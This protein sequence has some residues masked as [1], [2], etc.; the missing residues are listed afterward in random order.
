M[1]VTSSRNSETWLAVTSPGKSQ[2]NRDFFRPSASASPYP[3]LVRTL[4]KGRSCRHLSRVPAAAVPPASL[5]RMAARTALARSGPK[6]S[7]TART[8]ASSSLVTSVLSSASSFRSFLRV[9]DLS[10]DFRPDFFT[11]DF[12]DVPSRPVVASVASV[13]FFSSMT[14]STMMPSSSLAGTYSSP[15]PS[16][17]S[18]PTSTD[19][20]FISSVMTLSVIFRCSDTISATNRPPRVNNSFSTRI[21]SVF[22]PGVR[23]V[24]PLAIDRLRAR[25]KL[26]LR[27]LAAANALDSVAAVRE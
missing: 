23:G 2:T 1:A 3:R 18:S 5:P 7:M 15:S 16:A 14:A 26:A 9:R 22:S 4:F 21:R 12:L 27:S 11:S 20:L 8:K 6:I 24:S 25:S 19:M 17:S 13:T 10:M